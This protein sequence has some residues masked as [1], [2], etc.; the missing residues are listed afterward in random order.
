M[1]PSATFDRLDI[2]RDGVITPN[3]W[4]RR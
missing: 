2:N 1:G 3:E 4:P